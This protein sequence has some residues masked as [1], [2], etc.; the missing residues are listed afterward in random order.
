[1]FI[2]IWAVAGRW[3]YWKVW[4]LAENIRLETRF[5]TENIWFEIRKIL[6]IAGD[7]KDLGVD[8]GRPS[9]VRR[10]VFL[11]HFIPFALIMVLDYATICI[12]SVRIHHF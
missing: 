2:W 11:R 1:V 6:D 3:D 9:A 4:R 8:L 5:F 10:P 12:L 7:Y